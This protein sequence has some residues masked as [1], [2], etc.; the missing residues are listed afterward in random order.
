VQNCDLY[1]DK[2][3]G[4]CAH[5]DGP[6][7]DFPCSMLK[8]YRAGATPPA[9]AAPVPFA[10]DW[11]PIATAPK[12]GR[13]LLLGHFNSNGKWRALR[14]QWFSTGVIKET[15]EEMDREGWYETSVECD[16]DVSAWKTEPT[17]WM[18]LPAPPEQEAAPQGAQEGAQ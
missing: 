12:D 6:L 3:V 9:P 7:C 11:Q 4:G 18:P 16:G 17:H 15:W 10:A 13:T 2:A 8:G 1:R 5:V 14:G